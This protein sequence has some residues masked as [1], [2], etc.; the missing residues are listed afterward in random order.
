M[1]QNDGKQKK[2]PVS[3]VNIPTMN[4]V[5]TMQTNKSC[6]RVIA[7]NKTLWVRSC[8]SCFGSQF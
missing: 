7:T 6:S 3:N 1:A 4:I 5:G 8:L 2:K